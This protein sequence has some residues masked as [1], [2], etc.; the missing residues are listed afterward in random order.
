MSVKLSSVGLTPARSVAI[1]RST[2][3][4]GVSVSTMKHEIP[5]RPEPGPPVRAKTRPKS[6]LCASLMKILP[7]LRIQSSPSRT[8]LVRIVV[9]GSLPPAVSVRPKNARFSP[10]RRGS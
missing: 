10:R 3:K 7:P 6:A 5:P 9:A 2:A 4:P 1:T 8:A